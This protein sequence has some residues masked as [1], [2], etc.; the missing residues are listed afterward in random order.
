MD[1]QLVEFTRTALA[2]GETRDAI[3]QAL[4]R[5]GW[6]E[7]DIRGALGV[8]ADIEF[9]VPV[10][11]PRPYL[12]AR[13]VFVY[14]VLFVAL[15]VS[16]YSVGAL[17]FEFINRGFP[18]VVAENPYRSAYSDSTIRW[19]IASLVVW[20]P[21]FLVTFRGVTRAIAA[22]QTKRQSRP[23]RWLT[24]LTLFAA[25]VSIAADIIALIY[26]ALGG[27]LTLR[28]ILKFLTVAIL[29]G[30]IFIYFLADI[31]KEEAG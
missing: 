6:R 28:F 24:Y 27:E 13:E 10:P 14:L 21:I 4:R 18:D 25:V 30:G 8:F 16:A 12:S 23:R 26:N 17:T 1:A 3:A 15:Y 20:F 29:A 9:P 19:Q 5:A 7:E 22:D 11:R 31:R 2:R